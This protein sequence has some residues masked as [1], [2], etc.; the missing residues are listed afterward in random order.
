MFFYQRLLRE[1][2]VVAF[3]VAVLLKGGEIS[4]FVG[5]I[6]SG[7][8]NVYRETEA[9]VKLPLGKMVK[10]IRQVL[11]GHLHEKQSFGEVSIL[12]QTPFTCR[13]ITATDVKLGIIDASDILG[14]Y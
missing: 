5:F 7:Y 2:L 13:V 8:C 10:Q 6:K 3:L 14:K 4:T 1:F 9:L 12:L 11:V